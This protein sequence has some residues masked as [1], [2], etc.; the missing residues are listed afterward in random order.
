MTNSLK[1]FFEPAGVAI[2]GAS[3][4]PDKLSNG[5][6]KNLIQ[7]GYQGGIYPVNPKNTE[8]LG[9]TCYA[10]ITF[11]PDPVDLAVIVLP[12]PYIASVLEDCGK[13]GIKAVTVI[14]GGFKEIGEQGKE[15]EAQIFDIVKQY[16][17][18]MIG[19]NCVGTFNLINGMNT[20]FIKGK[21][22][23]GGI[24]FV[25][26]SGAVC[27]GIVD[28]VL[29]NG[30]GFSHFLSLGNEADVSETDM[31]EYL[32][33]DK[34]TS[35][36]AIYAEGIKD[37]Q[38][39]IQTAKQVTRRKPVLI[40]K[41]GRSDEGARAVSSH[42]GSLA[43]SHA[44][45]QA[46][47]Q[48]SGVIEVQNSTDLLN[49]AM[50]MDWLKLP[51]GNRAA[52]VTNAGGPA[53]LASDSL[54]EYGIHLAELSQTTQDKLR[55]KLNPA[56]QA[57]N[58]VDMLGGATETEY[59]H[60][61]DCVL[62]DEGVDM[63]LGVL[64]PQA[65]VDPLK[66]AQAMLESAR[67]SDKPLLVCIMGSSSV[68]AARKLLHE[69]HQP[70]VDY[71]ENCGVMLGSL[72]QYAAYLKTEPEENI[73]S[74]SS[75][76]KDKAASILDGSSLKLWGEHAARPLLA[77]YGVSLIEGQLAN[78]LPQALEAANN[79]AYPVVMKVASEDVLHKSDFGAIAVNIRNDE[80]LEGAYAQ[81]IGNVK[82]HEPKAR[83]EGV[84]VEKMAPKGQE[85]IVGMKRDPGF[86]PLMMF[87]MGGVFVELF[88]DVAF[89]VA[90]L[91]YRDAAAMLQ[92]TKAYKLLSGWR[93]G[94]TY[95]LEAII[96]NLLKLSQLA[97]DFPQI[98]EIEINPLL[99][100]PQEQGA[101]ALDCRMILK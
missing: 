101:L 88:K 74:V 4:K 35:V 85:V 54:A 2:I 86:G 41:A 11:V 52:I 100:L 78:D 95:D 23:T 18:R 80:E 37:G 15:L 81:I 69:N 40:L 63:A 19:P 25:S 42:T 46:A 99:A 10:D 72:C 93:G 70:M 31:M 13:R 98:Q 68:H 34:H 6:L 56:A 33:E 21:P 65:L 50:A 36:I 9:K 57:A 94:E 67:K 71:P 3:D 82:A 84:L 43:G 24:G 96:Q 48:Q 97:M 45:Y 59:G 75:K 16:G 87:G 55:E 90:P 66:V 76:N 64:V 39:F 92:G 79:L 49:V 8:I 91:S 53:A 12:A 44:A 29:D 27:G 83:I 61:L 28:H 20:T 30:I 17:M 47:F 62:A 38:R 60:A 5:M 51:K 73:A 22:A 26:Q 7:Y 58:P 1:S 89:R 77:T 14:S 32:V